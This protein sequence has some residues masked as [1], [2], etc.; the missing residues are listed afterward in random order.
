[1]L[2]GMLSIGAAVLG[3]WHVLAVDIDEAALE[4]CRQ[5]L[6]DQECSMVCRFI[7]FSCWVASLLRSALNTLADSFEHLHMCDAC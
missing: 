1:M 7:L 4:L 5:N 2:Q 3:A 6:A